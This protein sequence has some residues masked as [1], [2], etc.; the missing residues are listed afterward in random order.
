[1]GAAYSE[2]FQQ[3][4]DH[5]PFEVYASHAES[6]LASGLGPPIV[7]GQRVVGSMAAHLGADIDGSVS[8]ARRRLVQLLLNWRVA[9]LRGDAD[10]PWVYTMHEHLFDLGAGEVDERDPNDRQRNASRGQV[11][12]SDLKAI[13]RSMDELASLSTWHGVAGSDGGVL[14]WTPPT[15]VDAEG[16]T[17]AYVTEAGEP[18]SDFDRESYPYL[19]LVAERLANGHLRCIAKLGLVDA[20]VFDRC[21][22]GWAWGEESPGY[23]CVDTKPPAEVA[24]FVGTVEQ[25]LPLSVPDA[26]S[27]PITADQ[28]GA[29]DRCPGGIWLPVS[30]LIVEPNSGERLFSEGCD[31]ISFDRQ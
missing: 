8:A 12:R 18:I 1:L 2:C 22:S 16:S 31:T 25:C 3:A 21:D 9:G 27:A 17:F 26:M 6:A 13:S 20:F 11:F 29:L 10:R 4:V 14:R 23:H 15:T 7:P 28:M 24:V 5:P 19:P 30:G